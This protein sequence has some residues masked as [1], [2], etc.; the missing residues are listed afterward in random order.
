MK[1]SVPINHHYY[2][3][4]FFNEAV[5]AEQFSIKK[6]KS[7][8]QL[9]LDLF[10]EKIDITTKMESL[11]KV[12]VFGFKGETEGRFDD[13]KLI[14]SLYKKSGLDNKYQ[15]KVQTGL[16]SG[17]LYH[18]GYQFN[19][20]S[21]Y[22]DVFSKRMLNFVSDIFVDNR[23]SPAEKSGETTEFQR[24]I[25]YL[26]IQSLEKA[27]V[28]GLPKVYRDVSQ[29][30][31]KVRGRVDIGEYLKRDYPFSGKITTSYRDQV[32]VQ[33]IVDL[34]F[35]ACKILEK[36][37][38]RE[39]HKKILG[40]FQLLKQ[41]YSGVY[42]QP[43][44]IEKAKAHSI[45]QNPVYSSFKKVLLYA[46]IILKE[47]SLRSS[48]SSDSL[49][50]HGY[51]F[52]MSQLFEVYLEKLLARHFSDWYVE[53][54]EELNVYDGLFF[55]RKMFP[56]LVMR[57]K[58][59]DRIIV[60]DAKFKTMRMR[61]GDL[62]R[63]DFYQIHSYIQ[64]YYPRAIIGGLIYPLKKPL[65]SERAHAKNL[66]GTQ[67]KQTSFIVDGI[68]IDESMTMSQILESEVSFLSR[69]ESLIDSHAD[70]DLVA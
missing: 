7:I 32:Y 67:K 56:D 54:Q 70:G 61:K 1:I 31:S 59:S 37:F 5:L 19:L 47:Q 48:A 44:T 53:G 42:P 2:E 62:D 66:M 13:D 22:G 68:Q 45:L 27:A 20:T 40:V 23:P 25:A 51:V 46:D 43:I 8:R 16:F 12:K 41:C 21:P 58:Y 4:Q 52:D 28:M 50:T 30:S 39:I 18:K 26:F 17:T 9:D 29:R 55:G 35:F 34:L 49:A 63:E 15:Y 3:D 6:P 36:N 64:Y 69:I 24:I 11:E 33:E 10:S 14:L 60:F 38:G 65:V 57:H